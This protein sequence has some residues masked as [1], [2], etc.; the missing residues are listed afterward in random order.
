MR[1]DIGDA[2]DD[3][4]TPA[5]QLGRGGV[6]Q[7]MPDL[8]CRVERLVHLC[9]DTGAVASYDEQPGSSVRRRRDHEMRR[10]GHIGDELLRSGDGV[11]PVDLIGA[12][13]IT[14]RVPVRATVGE[15]NAEDRRP[16]GDLRE[17][18]LRRISTTEQRVGGD[19]VGEIGTGV[20]ASS[21]LLEHDRGLDESGSAAAELFGYAQALGAHLVGEQQP[22]VA[23]QTLV[24]VHRAL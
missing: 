8:S 5:Y 13:L 6:Q 11:S 23:I 15:R 10:R 1:G 4:R 9:A 20:A 2:F 19:Q 3:R 24:A 7:Q 18:F 21:D 16:V 22:R 14:G 12:G 17:E